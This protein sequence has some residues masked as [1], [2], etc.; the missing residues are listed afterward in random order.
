MYNVDWPTIPASSFLVHFIASQLIRDGEYEI[1]VWIE[2]SIYNTADGVRR[3]G[4]SYSILHG[5]LYQDWTGEPKDI[6]IERPFEDM[7]KAEIYSTIPEE[8]RPFLWTCRQP[9][10]GRPCG[11][12]AKCS[13]LENVKNCAVA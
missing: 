6:S 13:E 3:R 4:F 10:D 5:G 9:M 11:K 7:T 12:C 8:V 1:D 2:T